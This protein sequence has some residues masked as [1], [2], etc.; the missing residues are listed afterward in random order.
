MRIAATGRIDLRS[1]RPLPLLALLAGLC[2][3]VLGCLSLVV[4]TPALPA[5]LCLAA[6]ALTLMGLLYEARNR[7]GV[8][9]ARFLL[10]AAFALASAVLI[11]ALPEYLYG[12]ELNGIIHRSLISSLMLIAVSLPATGH[13]LFYCLGATPSALDYAKYPLVLLPV[14]LA[15]AAYG[16]LISR[17]LALGIPQLDWH[18]IT[19]PFQWQHWKEMVYQD[20]WPSWLDRSLEQPGMLNHI[21]GTLL[22]MVMTT[23][24]SLPVGLGVGLF[25]NEYSIGLASSVVRFVTMSLRAISVIIIGLTALSLAQGAIGTAW[26]PFLA[27]YYYNNNGALTYGNGSFLLASLLLSLLVIPIIA[28]ATEEG[29]GSLP[30][31][32]REGSLALGA[33]QTYTLRRIILPWAMPNIITGLLLGCA[34]AAGSVAV[35]M[36]IAGSGDYGVAPLREVTSLSFFIFETHFG[37]LHFANLTR[38][39]QFGAALLLLLI[40]L[41][42]SVA[43]LILKRALS[44]RYR[45]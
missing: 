25:M 31:E 24:V 3:L 41:G 32:Q 39:Y 12:F 35:L 13:A 18:V 42:L 5:A 21:L 29:C 16:L 43:A 4:N 8:S 23:A 28:R 2:G 9:E 27:G 15:L 30:L 34:E 26:A 10:L 1:I 40:T 6:I 22:L 33:S 19:S 45:M 11:M 38:D 44:R 14:V 20:G 17:L 7:H 37:A 36:L